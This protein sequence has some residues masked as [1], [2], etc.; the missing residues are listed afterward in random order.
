M[1]TEEVPE[2]GDSKS[3]LYQ[4]AKAAVQDQN[5]KI[6]EEARARA[7]AKGRGIRIGV[8]A[9]IGVAGLVVLLLNPEWLTG[10]KAL[11]TEPPAIVAA[12][13]RLSL[14][15]ERQR[16]VDYGRQNGRLPVSS[17]EAGI[18]LAGISYAREGPDGFALSAQSGDSVIVLRSSD[19]MSSFLGSSLLTLRDRGRQ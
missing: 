6:A 1:M 3:S 13:L 9:L 15:R 4:A 2:L 5:E 10:P 19:S 8:L 7:G 12:A 14:L 16:V 11:P 17:Y 18:T